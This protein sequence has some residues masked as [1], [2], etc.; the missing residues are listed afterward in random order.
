MSVEISKIRF[1]FEDADYQLLDISKSIQFSSSMYN[2]ISAPSGWGKTTLF[3]V[4]SGWYEIDS[5]VELI[6]N[7][8][9][10]SEVFFI[11]NHQTLLPWK[12]VGRNLQIYSGRSISL[13]ELGK[14]LSRLN[15]EADILGKFP[16]QLSL[17]MY[18]RVE[19]ICAVLSNKS[20][21]ILDEFFASLDGESRD[22][23]Y[24]FINENR[25]CTYL[26]SSHHP[27]SLPF[28]EMTLY[29]LERD[30]KSGTIM[31]IVPAQ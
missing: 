5:S 23:A 1:G 15:L 27:K 16:Y 30:E 3:R 29:S 12:K 2:V 13:S 26:I 9:A 7:Y 31:N 17:G 10:P 11:G 22:L 4:L 8:T 14:Y 6:A 28:N 20:L 21:I 25:N 24:S 18:K 19:L